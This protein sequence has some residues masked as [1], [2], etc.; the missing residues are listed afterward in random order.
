VLALAVGHHPLAIPWLRLAPEASY[1][2]CEDDVHLV[3]ALAR[4]DEVMVVRLTATTR[5]LVASPPALRA[6]VALLLKTLPTLEQQGA[7]AAS[8]VL[9]TL[10]C[11]HVVVSL[12]RR[13]LSGRRG[14]FDD[15]RAV[16]QRVAAASRYRLAD[17]AVVG[18]ET[19]CHLLPVPS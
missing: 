7:G 14:Y 9:S 2:A 19:L 8:R 13:S 11:D 6:D 15:A 10:D 1:W 3:A 12:P 16:V 17:V 4:L 18:D 5:D